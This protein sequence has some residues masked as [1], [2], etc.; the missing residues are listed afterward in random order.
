MERGFSRRVRIRKVGGTQE[1]VLGL[2]EV[3]EGW[4]RHKPDVGRRYY[5]FQDNGKVLRTGV[6]QRVTTRGFQTENS[7][8][9][10]DEVPLRPVGPL[11][12]GGVDFLF[13]AQDTHGKPHRVCRPAKVK[14][15]C[16][17]GS[18]VVGH[19][20]LSCEPDGFDRV[21]EIFTEGEKPFVVVFNATSRGKGES[22][23]V[24]NKAHIIW[25]SPED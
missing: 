6:I 25:V 7:R 13:E 14:I 21:S 11:G 9:E 23:L 15:R 16:S 4:E 1:D 10:L 19:V 8:Y 5:V 18:T 20:N 3:R 12:D 22:V 24:I 2:E 17:D